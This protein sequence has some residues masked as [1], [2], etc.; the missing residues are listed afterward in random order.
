MPATNPRIMTAAILVGLF[1]LLAAAG[2]AQAG[3]VTR[4]GNTLVYTSKPG[5]SE[6][7]RIRQ[8]NATT[9]TF[10]DENLVLTMSGATGCIALNGD[11]SCDGTTWD[12][13]SVSLGDGGG[14]LSA[15]VTPAF[16]VTVPMAISAGAGN[17]TVS[18]GAGADNITLGAGDAMVN[19]GAGND[20]IANQGSM[21]ASGAA[22][23]DLIDGRGA[24]PADT[25]V[26]AGQ[27]GADTLLGGGARSSLHG[28]AGPDTLRGG[29]GDDELNGGSTE[30]GN[31]E[32]SDG[33]DRI[34]GGPGNDTISY[35]GRTTGVTV[36][37]AT[38]DGDGEAGEHDAV[39]LDVENARGG[40]AGDVLLGSAT[41]N[42]LLGS[43]GPDRIN[44][45]GGYDFLA[46]EAD[47]D[48]ITATGDG[49]AD[50]V[51]C[52]SDTTTAMPP[53]PDGIDADTANVD[54]LDLIA[55]RGDCE[56]VNRLA[57]PVLPPAQTQTGTSRP[58]TLRGTPRAD[59]LFGRGGNDTLYGFGGADQLRGEA[60]NDRLFGGL[61]NDTLDGGI[62]NDR[63][64]GGPGNDYLFGG[65][66][67]DVLDGGA[68]RDFLVS[69]D[70]TPDVVVCTKVNLAS[71]I[72]RLQRDVVIA[73]RRDTIRNRRWCA[74]VA[75]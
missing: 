69:R 37:L 40:E 61:G 71:R 46:G 23:D 67:R 55:L 17:E 43:R 32:T 8:P 54:H 34:S 13:L 3:V 11:V 72:Q 27:D 59:R 39:A 70:G 45:R 33:P 9:L 52:G 2:S 28:G 16:V 4:A 68:G 73:D 50:L 1:M 19:S 15:T 58:E 12:G 51:D 24:G 75:A 31:L 25:V 56:A 47:A 5:E 65:A 26:M 7:L 29:S 21:I 74:S 49:V 18:S 44:G 48:T 6:D 42:E 57:Q 66:G 10:D 62:G 30:V 41:S 20:V 22:G 53:L 35:A 14:R 63:L 38:A 36:D 64:L 60:G